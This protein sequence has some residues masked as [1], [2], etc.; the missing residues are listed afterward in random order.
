M[1]KLLTQG[2]F[3]CVYYPGIKCDG[4]PNNSKKVITKLQKMDMSAENEILIGKMI[5]KIENFHLFFSPVVKSCR[6]NL[7]N[8]DR[9]LL[10][11][12]EII[13]EKKEKN[14]ILLDML[15]INNNQFTELIKKMSK[16]NLIVTIFETYIFL[17]GSLELLLDSKIVHFDLK[18][19]NILY[20]KIT[21]NPILIDFGISIPIDKI[22]NMNIKDYLYVYAPDY[23]IWPLDVHI[24]T[25][26]LHKTQS[27][28][29]KQDAI[30]IASDYSKFNKGLESFSDEFKKQYK[31][32]CIEVAEQYVGMNR[33]LAIE[34]LMSS[35][36]T[37][38][39]YAISILYL[40]SFAFLF[41]KGFYKNELFIYFSQ[42]LLTNI[43]P[44]SNKRLSV[45]ETKTKFSEMF[46]TNET[47]ENYVDF[48]NEF[49]YS[50]RTVTEKIRE[51]INNLNDILI[52][53]SKKVGRNVS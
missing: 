11:K 24:I 9:S 26:L 17:L 31:I 2:G 33:N 41:E 35:Y 43:S 25:F 8:V 39:N 30:V 4:R 28:L 27:T 14:Y 23:C 3:G 40:K 20:D 6:V 46:Y 34:K 18:N 53:K 49:D 51:D 10:S 37:W 29:T 21:N 16:K 32:F 7:A 5:N 42:L 48:V 19:D 50:E 13:D 47:V 15:Y 1:S 22:N 44:D 52:I 38:D 36:K 12:C 45:S